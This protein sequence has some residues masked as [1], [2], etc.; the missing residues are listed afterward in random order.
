MSV[1]QLID[2]GKVLFQ[3]GQVPDAIARW[4]QALRTEPEN[5]EAQALLRQA[6]TAQRSMPGERTQTLRAFTEGLQDSEASRRLAEEK[7]KQGVLLLKHGRTAEAVESLEAAH[8]LDPGREEI[9]RQLAKSKEQYVLEEKVEEI[10][11]AGLTHL[12]AGQFTDAV[13]RFLRVLAVDENHSRAKTSL[14]KAKAAMAA[15]PGVAGQDEFGGGAGKER[16][17]ELFRLGVEAYKRDDLNEAV[18]LWQEVISL[19][20][21]HPRAQKYREKALATLSKKDAPAPGKAAA[22][23]A[24]SRPAAPAVERPAPPRRVEPPPPPP[25]PV[26]ETEEL[27]WDPS[28]ASS[29][30][31]GSDDPFSFEMDLAA[32]SPLGEQHDF[33][34]ELSGPKSAEPPPAPARSSAS[35]AAAPAAGQDWFSDSAPADSRS[36]GVFISD[37]DVFD[38]TSSL[39]GVTGGADPFELAPSTPSSAPQRPATPIGSGAAPAAQNTSFDPFDISKPVGTSGVSSDSFDPFEIAPAPSSKPAA[40]PAQGGSRGTANIDPFAPSG[41]APK[42]Q[43]EIQLDSAPPEPRSD[44]G[45]SSAAPSSPDISLVAADFLGEVKASRV[46][47][48]SPPPSWIGGGTPDFVEAVAA[49]APQNPEVLLEEGRRSMAEERYE[50]AIHTFKRALEGDPDNADAKVLLDRAISC[51]SSREQLTHGLTSAEE[52]VTNGDW[53]SAG[54]HATR[55]LQLN[56]YL[57]RAQQI[58]TQAHTL[59]PPRPGAVAPDVSRAA[60]TGGGPVI[61]PFAVGRKHVSAL[62]PKS[63][64]PSTPRRW[65]IAFVALVLLGTAGFFVLQKWNERIEERAKLER[66]EEAR[67]EQQQQAKDLAT[68]AETLVKSGDA[69]RGRDLYNKASKLDPANNSIRNSLRDVQLSLDQQVQPFLDLAQQ[70][71]ERSAYDKAV[72]EALN[73]LKIDPSNSRAHAIQTS[74]KHYQETV[75]SSEEKIFRIAN[76]QKYIERGDQ[77]FLAKKYD[78]AHD[79]YQVAFDLS[80]K[81][82]VAEAKL[83]KVTGKLGELKLVR[84]R[85]DALLEEA[86]K[87]LEAKK[88]RAAMD[89]IQ[90]VL[91]A[92]PDSSKAAEAMARVQ[93]AYEEQKN[94]D[95]YKK[96]ALHYYQVGKEAQALEYFKKWLELEPDSREAKFYIEQLEK[97]EK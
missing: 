17:K 10:Y 54:R 3:D 60:A 37:S 95:L 38:A 12:N 29:G 45:A 78:E 92:V 44:W 15:A 56:P 96:Q 61:N 82:D 20:P 34:L 41:S 50:E 49:P 13:T 68:E 21:E 65:P 90:I 83:A 69:V 77:A 8:S 4:Q 40:A 28:P 25:A 55:L 88:Y 97:A 35:P 57:R 76:F 6:R 81:N 47:D 42:R 9:Q 23:P 11:Q 72:A 31:A 33:E 27:V 22:A 5:S 62:A 84:A 46:G 1:Q 48:T 64:K 19:D 16:A 85:E 73:A 14:E 93:A 80:P 24:V 75:G 18:R 30:S 79:L 94:L 43:A 91:E 39:A 53:E 59:S 51:V 32:P 67:R 86:R 89:K 66:A 2:E 63:Q 70:H 7:L 36:D 52:A 71:L 74:A 87:L 26:I 58:A